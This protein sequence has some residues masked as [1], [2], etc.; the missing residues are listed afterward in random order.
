MGN[1]AISN[2]F[3][4]CWPKFNSMSRKNFQ[5][6]IFKKTRQI[7]ALSCCKVFRRIFYIF[8]SARYELLNEIFF[9]SIFG[10][11]LKEIFIAHFLSCEISPSQQNNMSKMKNEGFWENI[12]WAFA[13]FYKGF[14]LGLF[15]KKNVKRYLLFSFL[16]ISVP[17]SML[18]DAICC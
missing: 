2:T 6:D 14:N 12:N 4:K 1:I 15:E 16:R 18:T 7:S 3:H 11:I 10:N 5:N 8:R 17:I 9:I 13:Q